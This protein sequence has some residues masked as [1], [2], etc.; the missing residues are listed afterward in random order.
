[1]RV[2]LI[3]AGAIGLYFGGKLQ[4]AGC[5]VQFLLRRDYSKLKANGLQ[6]YSPRGDFYLKEIQAVRDVREMHPVDLIL[7][8]LKT[9]GNQHYKTLI[10]PII[11]KN[12]AILTLQNGLGNEEE[13]AELFGAKR[14]LGGV[15]YICVNRGDC[16]TVHHLATGYIKIGAFLG[17]ESRLCQEISEIFSR[18]SVPCDVVT[19]IKKARWEKLIW[20]ITFNGLCALSGQTTKALM[21]HKGIRA[22]IEAIMKEILTAGNAQNLSEPIQESFIESML[23]ITDKEIGDYR[24]S[25]MIDRMN[26]NALELHALFKNPLTAAAEKSV[27]MPRVHLLYNLLALGDSFSKSPL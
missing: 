19:D 24:P 1:M 10:S 8:C 20:N 18:V 26:G 14:V 21:N 23:A 5:D 12:T 7:V 15:A 27:E 9:T 4:Q 11:N 25:M 22:D 13:L 2:A 17:G 16:G 3:G 6:V